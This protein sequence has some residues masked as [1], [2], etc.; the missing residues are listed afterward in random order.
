MMGAMV[1]QLKEMSKGY[2]PMDMDNP[3][4]WTKA[5]NQGGAGSL[6]GEMIAGDSR[7]YGGSF[8]DVLGGPA[9]GMANQVLYEGVFGSLDDVRTTDK[10]AD[11]YKAK[12]A[13]LSTGQVPHLWYT[14]AIVNRFLLD[15][16]NRAADSSYDFKQMSKDRKRRKELGNERFF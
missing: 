15:E 2:T 5:F 9:V 7:M 10:K 13:R 16:I 6:I 14:K 8:A 3:E 1:V 12:A 11:T 4:F